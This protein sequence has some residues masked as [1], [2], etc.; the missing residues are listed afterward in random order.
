MYIMPRLKKLIAG[1]RDLIR[2]ISI[3]NIVASPL[4]CTILNHCISLWVLIYSVCVSTAILMMAPDMYD[5]GRASGVIAFLTFI[6]SSLLSAVSGCRM[7]SARLMPMYLA[8]A[9]APL[10]VCLTVRTYKMMHDLDYLTMKVS[11]WEMMLCSIKHCFIAFFMVFSIGLDVSSSLLSVEHPFMPHLALAVSAMFYVLMFIRSMTSCP[12][13]AY[14]GSGI[15]SGESD[16]ET[17]AFFPEKSRTD[18]Q[19]MYD[20]MCQYL[21]E[22]KPYLDSSYSM[23]DMVMEL[24]SNKSYISK[25]INACTGLNFSQMINRYR[26]SYA[27]D[28]FLRNPD[29]KVKDLADMSGF[30]S[31]VT[32][33]MAFKLFSGGVTP[34]V[35][36]KE[37]RDSLM[38]GERLSSRQG[39]E[40]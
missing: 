24:C 17:S 6:A 29:L 3:L 37:T 5:D 26:I 39:Q 32:F 40:P 19:N 28:E 22:K 15:P 38:D 8:V 4:F 18:Y 16:V 34:G 25:L 12:I 31:Q 1:H 10:A 13:V 20:R 27:R 36:C 14:S 11:G 33:N 7:M 23:D 9:S 35:W 2:L 21:D 30:H